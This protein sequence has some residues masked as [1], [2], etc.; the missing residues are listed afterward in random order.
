VFPFLSNVQ[1]GSGA[2]PVSY[3][4]GTGGS[5]PGVKWPVREANHSPPSSAEVKNGVAMSPLPLHGVVL[6]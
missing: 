6:N 5:S 4:M 2:H 3:Q 1:T